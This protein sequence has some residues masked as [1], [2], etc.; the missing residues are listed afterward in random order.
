MVRHGH[1]HR[2]LH[3]KKHKDWFDYFLYSIMVATPLFELPQAWAIYNTH[4]AANVSLTTWGF[5]S[6]A[7]IAWIIYAVRNKYWPLVV[8]S[9]LY[10]V[11]EITIVVGI[12]LY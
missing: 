3:R 6:F 2:H 12:V 1:G 9:S 7:N 4:S 10:M 5:F 8:T 11:I